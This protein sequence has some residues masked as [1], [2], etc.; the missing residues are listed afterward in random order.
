MLSGLSVML[1]FLTGDAL[2]TFA[3]AIASWFYP[4]LPSTEDVPARVGPGDVYHT[5]C[6]L[7]GV[8]LMVCAAVPAGRIVNAAL[9]G[10]PFTMAGDTLTLI[11]YLAN[12]VLLVFGAQRVSNFLTNLRYDPDTVPQQR[13]TLAVLLVVMLLFALLLG[14]VR[15]ASTGSV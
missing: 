3:P 13:I 2:V 7:L 12:G 10:A 11:V 5:G 15:W 4:Q 9:R 6:F 8:Y 1:Y 14:A